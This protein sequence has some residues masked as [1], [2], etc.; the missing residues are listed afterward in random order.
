MRGYRVGIVNP[1]T[2]FGERVRELLSEQHVPVIEMKLFDGQLDG[3]T[4][5]AQFNDEVVVTQPLDPDALAHLDV[6]FFAGQN[7]DLMNRIATETAAGGVLTFIEGALGLDAPIALP[8]L[9]DGV[10]DAK[11]PNVVPRMASFLVGT[12]LERAKNS[13]GLTNAI[14]TVFLPAADRGAAG[15][16]ELHEQVLSI[17][18]FQ[19]PPTQVLGEQVAFNV[20]VAHNGPK[21]G[22]LAQ[23]VAAEASGL[24]G[25]DDVLTVNLVQV[26]VFHG[27]AASLWIE[28]DNPD[29]PVDQRAVAAAFREAPFELSKARSA[30]TPSPLSIAESTRIHVGGLRRSDETSRPGVWLWVVADTTAYDPGS[31]ALE[32]AK[33]AL[34]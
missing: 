11:R 16:A 19:S 8:G 9:G 17:L 13:F 31:A 6:V 27:Y 24:A 25:L 30:K 26:P 21:A 34:S 2:P 28:L 10:I 29:A 23:A 20:N 33:A 4:T 7:S 15:A 18:N 12:V 3:E 1:R 22:A 14:A 5:L 32:L